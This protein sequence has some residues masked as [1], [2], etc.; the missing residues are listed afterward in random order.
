MKKYPFSKKERLRKS[1]E[2]NYIYKAGKRLRREEFTIF[3]A[4]SR[5]KTGRI[6]VSMKR[7][8]A[9]AVERNRLKRRI[10]EAYRLNK[11]ELKNSYDIVIKPKK[12]MACLSFN[13][14]ESRLVKAFREISGKCG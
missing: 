11:H 2:Y 8:T 12:I 14:V 1:S 9:K 3:F 4:P 5:E 6:G 13:Q 10:K 7:D